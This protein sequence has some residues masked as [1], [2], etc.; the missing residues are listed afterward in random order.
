MTQSASQAPPGYLV[1]EPGAI[2]FL[3]PVKTGW[4]HEEAYALL[5][6]RMPY[7]DVIV[8]AA[9]VHTGAMIAY[10][11]SSDDLAELVIDE[12]DAEPLEQLH[13]TAMFLGEADEYDDEM[14]TRV[15][16]AIRAFAERQPVV[17]GDVFGYSVWNPDGE[18]CLVADVGGIDLEDAQN[19]L[20]E[21]CDDL[22][23][24]IPDQHVPWRPH[25]T[26]AYAE[27]PRIL[28]TDELMTKT[29]PIT[30]DRVRVAFGGVVTDYPLGAVTAAGV[31]EPFH[32]A[33]KHDQATHGR[34][35]LAEHAS[36][37]EIRAAQ[38]LNKG[39]R[40]DMSDP[41]ERSIA[42]SIY[43][44]TK[45]P[46]APSGIRATLRDPHREGADAAFTRAV[47]AAPAGAPKLHRGMRDVPPADLPQEGDVFDIGP[48]SFSRSEKVSERF[49]VT[50]GRKTMRT[51]SGEDKVIIE[52]N[53]VHMTVASGSRS[54]RV[55]QHSYFDDEQE[56][57]T[58]GRF[59][60]KSRREKEV[61]GKLSDGTK[62]TFTR[63]EIELEQ[64]DPSVHAITHTTFGDRYKISE[65][66]G[67]STSSTTSDGINLDYYGG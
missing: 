62:G 23:M 65:I 25:I 14:R 20:C 50:G 29:G 15:H 59:R 52:G 53:S 37:G 3:P 21:L 36:D 35:G 12:E 40:L 28:M 58:M 7:I 43:S 34:G 24:G 11:P 26:L 19:A 45:E 4:T 48:T 38:K 18:A 10:V 64:V 32:L 41:T 2:E 13:C 56:H 9:D 31:F 60:V 1:T 54:L 8:A 49:S 42:D 63:I 22:E 47:A 17:R 6:G 16:E 39:K 27:D 33:G 44:Y 55:D 66:D 61:T 46:G 67:V 30:F 57:I 51:T 5:M